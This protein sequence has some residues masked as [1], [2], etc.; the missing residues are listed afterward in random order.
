MG[1][2]SLSCSCFV[3]RLPG[4]DNGEKGAW[5]GGWYM[6]IPATIHTPTPELLNRLGMSGW[7]KSHPRDAPGQV[8]EVPMALLA[9]KLTPYLKP[10]IL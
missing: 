1:H 8:F 7:Y 5:E 4:P 10:P 6:H 3:G 2:Q 9:L